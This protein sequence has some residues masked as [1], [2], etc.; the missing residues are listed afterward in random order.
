M[1]K[2]KSMPTLLA[3]AVNLLGI[4]V[5]MASCNGNKSDGRPEVIQR[6]TTGVLALYRSAVKDE[7]RYDIIQR[8]VTDSLMFV[9]TDTMTMKKKWTKDTTYLVTY[10]TPVDT[11][12]A[13]QYKV[14]LKDSLGRATIINLIVPTPKRFVRSGWDRVDSIII[15]EMLQRK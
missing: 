5:V 15:K 9:D 2:S 3:N 13:K 12:L 7:V 1:K 4:I 6:D 11:F 8:V 10:P 14:P